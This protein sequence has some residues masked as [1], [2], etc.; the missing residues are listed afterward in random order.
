MRA[1]FVA[2]AAVCEFPLM[3][4]HHFF[5]GVTVVPL[6]GSEFVQHTIL[7]GSAFWF[8]DA[9]KFV[10]ESARAFIRTI[11]AFLKAKDDNDGPDTHRPA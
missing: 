3:A 8:E 6:G 9:R 2:F 4:A 1:W 11:R 10:G 5:P 7:V